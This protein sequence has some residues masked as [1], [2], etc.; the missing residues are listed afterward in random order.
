MNRR[1][2]LKGAALGTGAA[3]IGALPLPSPASAAPAGFPSY[4]YIGVPFDKAALRY[5]PTNE[6]IFPCIR[7][8]YDKISG[9]LGRYYLYYAPHEKP[10]GICLA[11]GNSL[12]GPF[13]EYAANPIISN[14]WSPYYSV[15]HVSSPYVLW[16]ASNKKFYCYFHG[17]NNT[18]RMA[19][20]TDGINYTYFGVVL[21]TSMVPG[22]TETSYARVFE[23]TVTGLGNKYVMLFMGVTSGTRKIF[24]G[25]SSDAK[26]WQF[27]PTPLVYPTPDGQTDISGAHLLKR[28]GTAYVV[29]H[30]NGGD[31]YLTEVGNAFDRE[32]HLGAFHHALTGAPDNGRSAAPSF[33]TDGGV[34]YMFYEAGPRLQA[35]IAVARAI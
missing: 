15:S 31:M 7:G 16:S 30:G 5:N 6:L 12:G 8:V 19:W 2:L 29:Y 3:A 35:T 25:W 34:E 26:S 1:Q 11:Y 10:G 20:S 22:T 24:W 21:S 18:T 32:V 4:Q 13:T 23:H 17:E 9:G 33:G 14:T 28:N 27:D